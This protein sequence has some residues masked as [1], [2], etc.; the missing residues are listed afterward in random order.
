MN[1]RRALSAI[2]VAIGTAIVLFSAGCTTITLPKSGQTANDKKNLPLSKVNID[3]W[4]K[5]LPV[6]NISIYPNSG[7][8]A[9][10][11]AKVQNTSK[12]E[13]EIV[14]LVAIAGDDKKVGNA[15]VYDLKPGEV[16]TFEIQTGQYI[17][18]FVKE[19]EVRVDGVRIKG[20]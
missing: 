9:R 16:K 7:K 5:Q 13:V 10:I 14:K 4:R 12:Q 1:Q 18:D 3:E 2:S 15:T 19:A 6:E 11:Y 17:S 8:L 20:Q